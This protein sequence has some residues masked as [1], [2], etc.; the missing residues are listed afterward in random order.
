MQPR[1]RAQEMAG[2]QALFIAMGKF[3]K[4]ERRSYL[5]RTGTEWVRGVK[6]TIE[7]EMAPDQSLPIS[8]RGNYANSFRY[9]LHDDTATGQNPSLHFRIDRASPAARY[10]HNVEFG[11]PV[12]EIDWGKLRQWAWSRFPAEDA[13]YIY[14]SILRYATVGGHRGYPFPI[15]SKQS[16]PLGQRRLKESPALR[17]WVDINPSTYAVMGVTK[18][19]EMLFSEMFVWFTE[20]LVRW[21]RG[22]RKY[23]SSFTLH[24]PRT[25]TGQSFGAGAQQGRITD[26][27]SNVSL[28][29]FERGALR[30]QPQIYDTVIREL[31]A[32]YKQFDD[33][34]K[35][36]HSDNPIRQMCLCGLSL[37]YDLLFAEVGFQV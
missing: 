37:S 22:G 9:D 29:P 20:S 4:E 17:K 19:S 12:N 11:T 27:P 6:Y 28:L 34:F 23:F 3:Y 13:A 21:T 33:A 8:W 1:F 31:R 35:K 25:P 26:T 32:D 7:N 24:D 15:A 36:W 10:W 18:R 2:M 16:G 14:N 30:K 5:T